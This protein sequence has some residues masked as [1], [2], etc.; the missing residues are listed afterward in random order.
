MHS[1]SKVA[2]A[3]ALLVL[4]AAVSFSQTHSIIRP[5]LSAYE[6]RIPY[7]IPFRL[8]QHPRVALILS[9]GGAR[10]ISQIGVLKAFEKHNIPIDLIVGTSMGS[11]I[12]G[13][14]ACGYDADDLKRIVDSTDWEETLS[15]TDEARRTD[16][17]VDQKATR[18]RSFLAIRFDGLQPIIPSS[19]SS[20]QRL[21]N[22][23]NRLIL[24]GLYRSTPT[25]DDL[26]C[27]FRVVV[28]DLVSGKRVVLG[29]G[30]LTEALRASATVPLVFSPV[31]KDSML[32]MDGGL[33][34]NIPVDVARQEGMDLVI[35]V[36][37]TSPFRSA[38]Q[39]VA[40]WETADQIISIMQQLSNQEQL[41]KADVVVAPQLGSHLSSDFTSLD[42]L[43]N[44]GEQAGEEKV[45]EIRSRLW[46][47]LYAQRGSSSAL[48]E[49]FTVDFKGAPIPDSLKRVILSE[50]EL[51][52]DDRAIERHLAE[53][54][55]LGYYADV[56]AEVRD[57][58]SGSHITYV[59]EY[60]PTLRG[61][62]FKGALVLGDSL[63]MEKFHPLIG[64]VINHYEGRK[65]LESMLRRYRDEGYSL[66]RIDSADF[67][68]ENGVATVWV[69]EGRIRKL[70]IE[71][72][73][74]TRDY[75]IL[76]EFPL[77]EEDFFSLE[78]A[79][80]GVRHIMSTNLFQ[81]VLL[82][83]TYEEERPVLIIKVKEKSS[84]LARFGLRVDNERNTQFSL[85]VRNENLQGTG[86]EIGFDFAGGARNRQ[87]RLEYKANRIFNSYFSFDLDAYHKLRDI[88]TYRDGP[89]SGITRW[90]RDQIGEYREI[91]YG[92]SL[93]LGTQVG[94]LGKV[95]GELRIEQHEIKGIS[96]SGYAPESYSVIGLKLSSTI[97]TENRYPFPTDGM[98]MRTYYESGL[99]ELGK[100]VS[101]SKIFF[102]YE[103]FTTHFKIHTIHPKITFG[104]A[105]ET[106]P[107]SEQFSIGG[108]E[109]L[110][111][112]RNDDRRGRQIFLINFEYRLRLPFK[113]L[114]DTYLKLRYD[115]GSVWRVPEDIVLR[116]LHHGIGAELALDTPIGPAQFAV[117]RSFLFR[118]DLLNNPLSFGPFQVYFSV[119]YRLY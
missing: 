52:I 71:G 94:R 21:T 70:K 23:L 62:K 118:R 111:G 34:S 91:K 89:S 80:L 97:D 19:I 38:D 81:Q 45:A 55:V 92:G 37:A 28:T 30:D 106:L 68:R 31:K 44:L 8:L 54:Y 22:M 90:M 115:L 110:L 114:F 40:P 108:Q 86:T 66:A 76:R 9:G 16:L 116:D 104:Y 61:V 35:A 112:L 42:S 41:R 5:Q 56:Y 85:D 87:F 50:H 18:E 83:V 93:T 24:Q 102:T 12:G 32:L 119:G 57:D 96:G 65:A 33:V 79:N 100:E 60:N 29:R 82:N 53:I 95:A 51:G 107:L 3:T 75:V 88:F 99:A 105:N 98:F 14:Y 117:G 27:S 78:K 59:A 10:G 84:E 101:Y 63:L 4:L 13:L 15:L 20:G 17:F 11:I 49:N 67:D 2:V 74:R 113:V 109:S 25:F 47:S 6:K 48:N 64:R 26:K 73:E 72:N 69:D 7:L 103:Y 43:I 1:R 77:A 36:N 46:P 58:S 39:L